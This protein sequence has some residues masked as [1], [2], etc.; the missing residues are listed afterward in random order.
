MT[1]YGHC[2]FCGVELQ[3]LLTSVY[4]PNDS[5]P[6]KVIEEWEKVGDTES[7]FSKCTHTS[8]YYSPDGSRC[9]SCGRRI[10]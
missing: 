6:A 2:A 10:R 7:L 8:K 9:W 1:D 5:C 4:C 3:I